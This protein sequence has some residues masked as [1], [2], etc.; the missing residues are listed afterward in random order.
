[1]HLR[2]GEAENEGKENQQRKEDNRTHTQDN[3]LTALCRIRR[4]QEKQ[5]SDQREGI[6]LGIG[7]AKF[8]C[9]AAE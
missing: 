6:A 9:R 5:Q 8:P 2:Q 1:M 3:R 4:K 7:G